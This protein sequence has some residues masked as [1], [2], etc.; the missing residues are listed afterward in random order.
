MKTY[1]ISFIISIII[2]TLY[3]LV[4]SSMREYKYINTKSKILTDTLITITNNKYDT[5]YTYKLI[6]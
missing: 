6:K 3:G 4:I 1:I 2:M 5:V